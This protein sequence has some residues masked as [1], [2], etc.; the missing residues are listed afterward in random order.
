VSAQRDRLAAH[1][2]GRQRCD[3]HR[4]AYSDDDVNSVAPDPL[5]ADV[6][7]AA[8]AHGIDG[9]PAWP[10]HAL[11]CDA[12]A[13]LLD[14]AATHRLLGAL[15]EACDACVMS[16]VEEDINTL[17]RE[18]SGWFWHSDEETLATEQREETE[19]W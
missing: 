9:A 17:R 10:P 4:C 7:R 6:L 5:V 12:F 1:G 8:V 13:E 19:R 14:A 18:R 11:E 3:V 2:D 16:Q 15:A